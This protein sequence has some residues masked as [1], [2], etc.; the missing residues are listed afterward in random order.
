MMY[1]KINLKSKS[2]IKSMRKDLLDKGINAKHISIEISC[3]IKI[4]FTI[5]P[6]EKF[7][8]EKMFVLVSM[9]ILRLS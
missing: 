5:V 4:I 9:T 7:Y 2:E 3:S 8:N 1:V 6:S